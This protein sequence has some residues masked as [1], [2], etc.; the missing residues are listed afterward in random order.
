MG[1]S[2]RFRLA[3]ATP[4]GPGTCRIREFGS[5]LRIFSRQEKVRTCQLDEIGNSGPDWF[6]HRG[7]QSTKNERE[8]QE[9]SHA[10][11]LK[12]LAVGAA[13]AVERVYLLAGP[14][15]QGRNTA[16]KITNLTSLW[17]LGRQAPSLGPTH[18]PFPI[19]LFP[20]VHTTRPLALSR[21][22]PSRLAVRIL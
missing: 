16:L 6:H 14:T 3:Q 19:P 8:L 11:S 4:N 9:A 15:G 17:M 18:A 10:K 5:L 7:R 20:T 12:Y 22:A 21:Y 1:L 2:D 13:T